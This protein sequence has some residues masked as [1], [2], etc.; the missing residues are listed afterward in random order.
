MRRWEGSAILEAAVGLAGL[1]YQKLNPVVN[2]GAAIT[3]PRPIIA[4]MAQS[5]SHKSSSPPIPSVASVPVATYSLKWECIVVRPT[6]SS[7][8]LSV[9]KAMHYMTIMVAVLTK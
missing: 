4:S 7:T 8:A 9:K 3:A 6:F 2:K 1:L 5:S